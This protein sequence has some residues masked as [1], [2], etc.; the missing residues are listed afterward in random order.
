VPQVLN[1]STSLPQEAVLALDKVVEQ[2]HVSLFIV[3]LTIE[4]APTMLSLEAHPTS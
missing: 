2:R 4:G 3:Q 1:D